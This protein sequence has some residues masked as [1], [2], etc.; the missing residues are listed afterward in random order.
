MRFAEAVGR[1]I[2]E[3]HESANKETVA[4]YS[5][6][7]PRAWHVPS[8]QKFSPGAAI[9]S[10]LLLIMKGGLKATSNDQIARTRILPPQETLTLVNMALEHRNSTGTYVSIVKALLISIQYC[11]KIQ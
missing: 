11:V 7:C 2:K 9:G 6:V 4:F 10:L 8:F 1:R 3:F 5:F